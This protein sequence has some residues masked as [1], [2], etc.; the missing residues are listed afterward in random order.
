[1]IFKQRMVSFDISAVKL[2][3]GEHTTELLER[4]NSAGE[5]RVSSRIKREY[6]MIILAGFESIVWSPVK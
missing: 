1:M 3:L 4:I 2:R 6:V 5:L